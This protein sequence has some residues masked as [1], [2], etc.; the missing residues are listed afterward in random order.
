MLTGLRNLQL[1]V[2]LLLSVFGQ[3]VP[4]SL[5]SSQPATASAPAEVT[6][7]KNDPYGFALEFPSD[8]TLC[9]PATGN[10]I[11]ARETVE[12][13]QPL[14]SAEIITVGVVP[15]PSEAT[16]IAHYLQTVRDL[17]AGLELFEPR[18][19]GQTR[20]A[21]YPAFRLEYSHRVGPDIHYVRL[22]GVLAKPRF[23][24]LSFSSQEGYFYGLHER[25]ESVI[26]SL[27]VFAPTSSPASAPAVGRE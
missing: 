26:R 6:P 22:I 19:F 9:E 11:E 13:G 27:Q 16:L 4:S 10:V 8:L 14:Q 2:L 3:S 25:F 21:G 23:Y 12:P 18:A 17:R 15:S 5:P 24:I 7:Y 1:G 20:I